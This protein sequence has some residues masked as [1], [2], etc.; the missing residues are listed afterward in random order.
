MGGGEGA[1]LGGCGVGEEVVE[2][3]EGM[4]GGVDFVIVKVS[5]GV[6]GVGV[7]EGVE[8]VV[9]LHC[10]VGHFFIRFECGRS[11]YPLVE[12]ALFLLVWN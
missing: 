7:S 6:V 2:P 1:V 10:V 4:F 3:A 11:F 9:Y 5:V 8:V 12:G